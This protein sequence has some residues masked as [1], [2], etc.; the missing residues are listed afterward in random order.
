MSITL[1]EK[2]EQGYPLSMGNTIRI[3]PIC[4]TKLPSVRKRWLAIP[5][6]KTVGVR[7][8]DFSYSSTKRSVNQL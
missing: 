5:I 6:N 1:E 8:T 2:E 3:I 7:K 4:E